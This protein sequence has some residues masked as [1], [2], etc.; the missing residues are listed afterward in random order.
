[1]RFR[2]KNMRRAQSGLSLMGFIFTLVP[3]LACAFVGMRAVP[4]Y[5]EFFSIKKVLQAT[6]DEVG[7]NASKPQYAQ[8]F[9]RRAQIDDINSIRG[10]DLRVS[11]EGAS[12]VLTAEYEKRLSLAGNVSLLFDFTAKATTSK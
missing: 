1:M 10:A 5:S 2:E 4:V 11:K 3:L 9:D 6:A 12:T 8:T 7:S